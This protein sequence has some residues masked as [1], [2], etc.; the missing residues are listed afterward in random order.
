VGDTICSARDMSKVLPL[1]A[2]VADYSLG[3][4]NSSLPL[5]PLQSSL[6]TIAISEGNSGC[7]S[8]WHTENDRCKIYLGSQT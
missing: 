6:G 4:A 2:G 7:Q 5:P 1:V 8:T 3:L